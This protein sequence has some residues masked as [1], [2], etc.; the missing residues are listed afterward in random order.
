MLAMSLP[1]LK[2]EIALQIEQSE[3]KYFALRLETLQDVPGN[4][5]GVEIRRYGD[6]WAMQ[7]RNTESYWFFHR[8]MAL[9]YSHLDDLGEILEWYRENKKRSRFDI[10]PSLASSGLLRSLADEG[11]YQSE[12]VAALYGLPSDEM[13]MPSNVT[14]RA[15]QP[16]EGDQLAR[17]YLDGYG[18]PEERR[19]FL[20]DSVRKLAGHPD[21]RCYFA[22]VDSAVAGMAVLYLNGDVGYLASGATLP[23]Y[24]GH[25]CRRALHYARLAAAR[26]EGC[27]LV[28]AHSDVLG[29]GQRSLEEVGMRVAYNKAIWTE[30]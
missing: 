11:F 25:G 19:R 7:A 28:V 13:R 8:V 30:L 16:Y 2:P 21:V 5:Y 22:Y 3:A 15:V 10:L 23:E 18:V 12:F 1:L 29:N 4:P 9:G 24:L 20:G 6:A 14:V 17:I 26:L 27:S